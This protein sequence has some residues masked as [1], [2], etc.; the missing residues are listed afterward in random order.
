M[1]ARVIVELTILEAVDSFYIK[2]PVF[3]SNYTL[4][5]VNVAQQR[6]RDTQ[7]Q[8]SNGDPLD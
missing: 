4:H 1:K 8:I 2:K 5:Q 6:K 7:T 3:Y